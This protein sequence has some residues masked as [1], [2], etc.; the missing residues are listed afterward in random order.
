MSTITTLGEGCFK[1][2]PCIAEPKR[3][4]KNCPLAFKPQN[5]VKET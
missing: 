2:L 3:K 1:P 4:K 5:L